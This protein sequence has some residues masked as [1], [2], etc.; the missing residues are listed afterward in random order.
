MAHFHLFAMG[1]LVMTLTHLLLFL[2]I[3]PRLKAG[4]VIAAFAAALLDEGAGWLVR[5]V[6]PGFAA[7]KVFAFLAL[8]AALL[9]LVIALFFGVLR[10]GRNAYESSARTGP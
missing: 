10:P 2:P 8:Q 5:F 4:L 9:A 7:V 1:V 3:S 6:H